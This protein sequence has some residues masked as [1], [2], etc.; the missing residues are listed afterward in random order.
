MLLYKKILA[1]QPKANKTLP[2]ENVK[3]SV[4]EVLYFFFQKKKKAL[5]ISVSLH[6][7]PTKYQ[8]QIRKIIFK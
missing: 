2:I 8:K 4:A 5:Y 1:H 3:F 6:F 7:Y